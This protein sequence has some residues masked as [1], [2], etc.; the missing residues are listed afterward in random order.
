MIAKP[1]IA[2]TDCGATT[3]FASLSAGVWRFCGTSAAAPHAAAVAAL[4]RQAKPTPARA[5][6]PLGPHGHRR[7]ESAP[8]A[9]RPPAP[10]SSTRSRRSTACRGRSKAATA[11][12]NRS[13]RSNRRPVSPPPAPAAR[14]SA[15]RAETPPHRGR[16]TRQILKHPPNL[17]RTA[18]RS[19]RLVFRFGADQAGATFL[20][21]VDRRA[22]R[23]CSQPLRPPLRA[24]PP[25]GQ[26]A[27]R[28][29]ADRTARPDARDLPLPGRAALLRLRPR[30]GAPAGA[31]SSGRRPAAPAARARCRA[32]AGR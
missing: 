18:A 22:Y 25:H 20:C 16:Q 6:G 32:P 10:A 23:A 30:R 3:F 5:A 4:V 13:R 19:A 31:S 27:E 29:G 17:V 11:P 7:A 2:A 24:R 8:S 14:S 9:R 12:A 26:G 1:D 28:S 21:K 15:A